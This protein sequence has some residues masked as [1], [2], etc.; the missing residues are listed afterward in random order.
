MVVISSF[1]LGGGDGST[2]DMVFKTKITNVDA[3]TTKM[4]LR[5]VVDWVLENS[6][7]TLV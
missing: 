3:P 5:E 6:Y 4:T 1:H 2:S 7:F